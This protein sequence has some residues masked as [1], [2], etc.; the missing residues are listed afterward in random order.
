VTVGVWVVV[1]L[2]GD[3]D[4]RGLRRPHALHTGNRSDGAELSIIT[5]TIIIIINMTITITSPPLALLF[6]L[7][8]LLVTRSP[9]ITG[10]VWCACPFQGGRLFTIFFAFTGISLIAV[11][12]GQVRRS[13]PIP[14]PKPS[15]PPLTWPDVPCRMCGL[16]AP[17]S[18]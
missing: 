10:L 6:L 17:S 9:P 1:G 13:R 15:S 18:L 11:A 2:S 3:A 14:P 16:S 8:L 5:I 7:L 12:L 4:E